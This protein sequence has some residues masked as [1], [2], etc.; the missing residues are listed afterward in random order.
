MKLNQNFLEHFPYILVDGL[1][2]VF[3]GTSLHILK[4]SEEVSIMLSVFSLVSLFVIFCGS[5]S[6]LLSFHAQKP[7]ENV[8]Q[9]LV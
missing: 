7:H 6:S 9:S 4:A 8:K 1:S 3:A 5:P 2:Y